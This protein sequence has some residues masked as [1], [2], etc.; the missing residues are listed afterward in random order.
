MV[1]GERP[2]QVVV[3]VSLQPRLP[4]CSWFLVLDSLVSRPAQSGS[5]ASGAISC[6]G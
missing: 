3:S 4:M 5:S 1:L 6:L 2:Y